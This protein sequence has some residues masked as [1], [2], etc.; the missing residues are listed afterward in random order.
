VRAYVQHAHGGPEACAFAEVAEPVPAAG[1]VVVQVRACGLNRLDLLQREAPLVRGFALPHVAGMDVVGTVV[2]RADDVVRPALGD[3]V[4]VDPVTTCRSCRWCTTGREPYCP[5]LRT[6]G[7]T[8]PGGFAERVAVPA[9]RCVAVPAHLDDVEAAAVPVAYATAWLAVVQV[10]DVQAGETV[11]VN[12]ANAGVSLAVA[13]VAGALGAAVL[14]TARG[15]DKVART[16]TLGYRAVVDATDPATVVPA[17]RALTGGDGVEV[18][19]DHLGPAQFAASVECLAVDGRMV[20]CGTTTGTRAEVDLPAVYWWGRRL[21]GAGG[22][23]HEGFRRMLELVATHRL[24]PVIAEAAPFAE[25]PR[26]L[27]VMARGDFVG[28]LVVTFP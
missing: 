11:L 15:A 10:A 13:Q 19:V 3:R 9:D 14:G 23:R 2:A 5:D 21:L 22:Y 26:L 20:L 24:R 17:V 18:V 4:L 28:K 12:G 25:L 8:R 6:V 27:D 7:S 1:E 16:S